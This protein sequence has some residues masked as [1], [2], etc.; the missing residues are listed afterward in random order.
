MLPFHTATASA[1]LTSM[2]SVAPRCYGWTFEGNCFLSIEGNC[3]S[4]LFFFFQIPH[5]NQTVSRNLFS[6][7]K[8]GIWRLIE[9]VN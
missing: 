6:G 1:L 4:A 9:K 3:S 5:F 2:L 7:Q 8:K